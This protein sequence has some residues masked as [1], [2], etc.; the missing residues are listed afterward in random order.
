[1]MASGDNVV[2]TVGAAM[3][4]AREQRAELVDV[5]GATAGGGKQRVRGGGGEDGGAS[6]GAA[7]ADV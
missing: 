7:A 6:V 3:A 2:I 5:R 4:V 1:M